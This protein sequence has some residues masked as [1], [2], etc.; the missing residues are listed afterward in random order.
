GGEDLGPTPTEIFLA[1]L[2]S[3]IMTNISRI[4]EKMRLGLRDVH[5]DISGVKEHNDHPSMFRSIKVNISIRSEVQDL[6]KLEK[7]I[8]LAEENCTVSNTLKNAI[9][10]SVSLKPPV[11]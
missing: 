11:R 7:L 4:G 6:E 10:P 3:C 9:K 8:R 1:S 2:G 5:M